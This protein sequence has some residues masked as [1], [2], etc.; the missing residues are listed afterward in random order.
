MFKVKGTYGQFEPKLFTDGTPVPSVK[1]GDQFTY[2]G[3]TFTFKMD[4]QEIKS[5]LIA[6]LKNLLEKIS[7]AKL[8]LQLKLK[9]VR[10]YLPT[11][12]N[13]QLRIYNFSQTWLENELDSLIT[14]CIRTWLQYPINSCVAEIIHLPLSYGGL[15]I[16]S[17]KTI[18]AKHNL[19][20]RAGLR[21]N[22]DPNMRLLWEMSSSKNIPT[23]ALILNSNLP[24]ANHKLL[25]ESVT[26]SLNHVKSLII[27]GPSI[28]SVNSELDKKEIKRWSNLSLTLPDNIFKFVRKGFQNQ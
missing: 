26:T 18:A 27:Q 19:S 12:F 11:Q 13:F 5:Q 22:D 25:Q 16:P 7:T 21:D 20:V 28:S 2:L 3:K 23:D 9:I 14:N 1:L 24:E 6:R 15:G 17:L 10:L 4:N 8:S